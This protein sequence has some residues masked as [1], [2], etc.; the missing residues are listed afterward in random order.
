MYVYKSF[1]SIYIS[2][3]IACQSKYNYPPEPLPLIVY[4]KSVATS[5]SSRRS[6]P[7]SWECIVGNATS[8]DKSTSKV[9]VKT[10]TGP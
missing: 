1:G 2:L 5:K 7:S 10:T 8:Q 3:N 6:D 4:D 9:F